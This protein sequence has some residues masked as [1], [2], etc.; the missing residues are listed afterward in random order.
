MNITSIAIALRCPCGREERCLAANS[1]GQE[2]PPIETEESAR[3]RGWTH[4]NH[5]PW[6]LWIC[7]N[8][9]PTDR[10]HYEA[11]F[12]LRIARMRGA[13]LRGRLEALLQWASGRLRDPFDDDAIVAE[14]ERLARGELSDCGL[15]RRL[16]RGS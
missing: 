12:V 4:S 16:S 9:P 13:S 11:D 1:P 14:V 7:P 10:E 8:H 6:Q 5:L 3:A 15:V 2:E